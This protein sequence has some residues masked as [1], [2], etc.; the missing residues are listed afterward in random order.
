MIKRYLLWLAI[1][2]ILVNP[3]KVS[4]QECYP[5]GTFTIAGYLFTCGNAVTCI[6]P[7]IGD[8]GKAAPGQGIF[9]HP[10]LNN[11]PPGIIGFVFAHECAHYRGD[12][13]EQRADRWAIKLGR[14]Q[15][16]ITPYTVRQIC[17][18]VYFTP[19]DWSH[20]PG[21]LR[22]QNMINAFTN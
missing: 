10:M 1:V 19:G 4:A 20:F 7:R 3:T 13:D 6:D 16:W 17:Q 18:S 11:Y 2:F 21:P 14:R 15:G 22:C 12:M 9:L 8:I 5:P